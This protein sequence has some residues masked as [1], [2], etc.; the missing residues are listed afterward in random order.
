MVIE[1][2]NKDLDILLRIMKDELGMKSKRHNSL[3]SIIK[4][5]EK[6]RDNFLSRKFYLS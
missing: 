4:L 2:D 6:C 5:L 1:S 3:D